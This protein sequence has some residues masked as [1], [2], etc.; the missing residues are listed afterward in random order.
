MLPLAIA[1]GVGVGYLCGGAIRGLAGLHLRGEVFLLCL[2]AIQLVLPALRV[3]GLYAR[4]AYAVWF[5]TFPL[6]VLA[7]LLNHRVPGTAVAAVGLG[8]NAAVIGVNSGMPVSPAAVA[9]AAPGTVFA[10][11]TGDFVHVVMS[12]ATRSPLLADVLP[13]PGPAGL[14][15]VASV[16]DVLLLCGVVG[17]IVSS[18]LTKKR[19]AGHL[20]RHA[21]RT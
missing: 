13:I 18:M 19:P 16:G 14:R 4:L 7:C 11:R 12:A 3:Q 9:A 1:A 20:P 17:V 5:G 2:L 6:M 15:S 10:L 21:A 8:L